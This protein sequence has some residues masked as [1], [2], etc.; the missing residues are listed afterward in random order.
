M[1]VTRCSVLDARCWSERSGDPENSGILDVGYSKF[2]VPSSKYPISDSLQ[3]PN[4][5]FPHSRDS[6]QALFSGG[7]DLYHPVSSIQYPVS[8]TEHRAPST[9]YREPSK[10]NQ[11]S[12]TV[13]NVKTA[14]KW[15]IIAFAGKT[16]EWRFLPGIYY[17]NLEYF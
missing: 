5:P 3:P 4:P 1:L 16:G 15:F 12:L 17:L 8:R 11:S 2:R 6:G 13:F 10:M 7:I 9:E 14:E